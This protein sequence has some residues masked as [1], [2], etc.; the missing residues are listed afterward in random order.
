MRRQICPHVDGEQEVD[1]FLALELGSEAGGG[2][3]LLGQRVGDDL[4]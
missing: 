3:L 2:D 1:L 4:V